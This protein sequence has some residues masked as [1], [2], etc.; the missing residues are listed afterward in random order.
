MTN[1][2]FAI[3]HRQAFITYCQALGECAN[4]HGP[5]ITKQFRR[6]VE[7]KLKAIRS[8]RISSKPDTFALI[9]NQ[10]E[11]VKHKGPKAKGIYDLHEI[12]KKHRAF[13]VD[14]S[15]FCVL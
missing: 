14:E 15:G 5:L 11:T 1:Y 2:E 8:S 9:G 4:P 7:K 13:V 6:D 12:P 3:K 10:K